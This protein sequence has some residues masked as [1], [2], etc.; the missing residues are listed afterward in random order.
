M[1]VP[2]RT[3]LGASTVVRKW[4]LDVN[5]GSVGAPVWTP[6]RGLMDFTPVLTPT[7]VDDS[8][9]DS[10]GYRSSTNTA[11]AWSITAT[12][13]RKTNVA[14]PTTYDAGQEALRVVSLLL[15]AS[16]SIQVRFYEYVATG[17]PITEAYSG[18]VAVTWSPKGG[19]M[20][21]VDEAAVT[22]TGQ[23]QRTTI[24][25]PA[26]G[27]STPVISSL[28]PAT[29]AVAGGAE[30][31]VLG[32]YFTGATSVAVAGTGVGAA[33]WAVVNDGEIIFVAPAKT[34]GSYAI[35]VVTPA[36]TSNAL[37]LVY[38]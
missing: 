37:N 28:V 24:A 18:Y 25:H 38:S 36:G 33:A 27:T 16:N 26:A 31:Q 8:D 22:L 4:L 9:F 7:V 11:L 20:D 19:A 12:A 5:T 32:Q 30:I 10:N 1:S 34:A 17:G 2:T 13:A 6:V 14:A 3:P 29:A 35:T 23:G 21:A 15:G